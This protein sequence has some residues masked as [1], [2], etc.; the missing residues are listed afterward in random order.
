MYATEIE[1]LLAR[2]VNAML[3]LAEPFFFLLFCL[4]QRRLATIRGKKKAKNYL[5]IDYP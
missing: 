1:A 5:S 3:H 4:N 2:L